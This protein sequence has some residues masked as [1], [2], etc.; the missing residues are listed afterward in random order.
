MRMLWWA[1][2]V[3]LN[4]KSVPLK[5]QTH[6]SWMTWGWVHF[7]QFV[8]FGWTAPLIKNNIRFSRIVLC[9]LI[10]TNVV[11]KRLLPSWKLLPITS[12]KMTHFCCYACSKH[13]NTELLFYAVHIWPECGLQ[14][15][16]VT[17]TFKDRRMI[18]CLACLI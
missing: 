7:Q 17:S 15:W 2:D 11:N 6:L 1:T 4:A 16:S 9:K 8:N 14:R 13:K 3:M 5:K 18:Q 12:Y 10:L